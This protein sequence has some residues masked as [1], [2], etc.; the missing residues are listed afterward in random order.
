M[1]GRGFSEDE[2]ERV[3]AEIREAGRECFAR[4]GL[5]KTT[6][7]D[8]TEPAGIANS[9][10]YRFFESKEALYV[11]I[12]REEGEEIAART[13]APFEETADPETA[14]RRFLRLIVGEIETNPLTR[15]LLVGGELDRIR[16]SLTEAEREALREEKLA[17]VVPHL[18]RWFEE[19]RLR[20]PDPETVA[21]AIR[22]ATFVT[23]HR[24][25]L[26]EERY[27]AVRDLL[28]ESVAAGLVRDVAGGSN[29]GGKADT[30]GE[31]DAGGSRRT[32]AGGRTDAE[33]GSDA[34]AT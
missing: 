1:T 9:T 26:G 14:I 34:D 20:G 3:A 21:G 15:R 22:A 24:E 11:E 5:D 17:F 30:R 7:A 31:A 2:R 13:L 12:L 4:Y 28:V 32:D 18:A 23:L 25:D 8:L 27:P 10:F 33:E 6:I 19:G 29:A 16:A